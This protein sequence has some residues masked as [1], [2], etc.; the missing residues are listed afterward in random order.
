M[1]LKLPTDGGLNGLKG[2]V[3][4]NEKSG[5]AENAPHLRRVQKQRRTDQERK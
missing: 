4:G 1:F 3:A 2:I 5:N